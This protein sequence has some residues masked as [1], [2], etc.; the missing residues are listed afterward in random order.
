MLAAY[1]R[2]KKRVPATAYGLNY[3][4]N[5]KKFNP[6]VEAFVPGLRIADRTQ[7]EGTFRQGEN[8]VLTLHAQADTVFYGRHAF[9]QNDLDLNTSKLP[10]S[11]D[12]L[13]NALV[14][15]GHQQLAGIECAIPA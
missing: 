7:I 2:E 9:Y 11:A 15:S 8:A 6:V 10:Y 13:A 3:T 1:Y 4:I 5:L 12:V 14:T